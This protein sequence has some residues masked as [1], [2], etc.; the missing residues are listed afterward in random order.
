MENTINDSNVGQL[1]MD[2]AKDKSKDRA[3]TTI[4]KYTTTEKVVTPFPVT[5][6]TTNTKQMAMPQ[7]TKIEVCTTK[8]SSTKMWGV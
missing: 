5:K 4:I 8:S 6:A 3:S 1:I 7:S 2:L